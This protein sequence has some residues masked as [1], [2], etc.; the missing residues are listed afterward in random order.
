MDAAGNFVVT[1]TGSSQ[2]GS[3]QGVYGQRYDAAGTAVGGEFQIN[4]YVSSDQQY[5]TVAMDNAGN[6]VVTWSSNGQD[7]SGYG[8]YGQRF[9]QYDTL[10][11]S[12]ESVVVPATGVVGRF[13]RRDVPARGRVGAHSVLNPANWSLLNV[14]T[15]LYENIQSIAITINNGVILSFTTPLS[16][17]D[18][19]LTAKETIHDAS[20][21]AL[22]GDGD[23]LAGGDFSQS[24]QVDRLIGE[25]PNFE[26]THTL[27]QISRHFTNRRSQWRWT[28]RAISS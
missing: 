22:D 1:W 13:F 24:L 27:V 4:T 26:S 2:D 21:N 19:V 14:G 10:S 6:F 5:S 18:Y 28:P 16:N 17:G 9:S 23:S 7:G 20:G 15:G 25:G 8:V 11:P 3:G 12:V